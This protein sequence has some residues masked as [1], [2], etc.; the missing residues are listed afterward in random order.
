MFYIIR[1]TYFVLTAI[2][3]ALVLPLALTGSRKWRNRAGYGM[4]VDNAG[5]V[6][7][8]A[9]S[10]GETRALA[11]FTREWRRRYPDTRF[12]ISV[13]TDNGYRVACE[14]FAEDIAADSASVVF[15]PVDF[16]VACA[17]ALSVTR[18]S[19]CVITETE[20][21]PHW[22][23]AVT[24]RA[25]PIALVNA[26][27]SER[28]FSRYQRLRSLASDLLTRYA[29]IACQTEGDRN[30]YVALGAAP[31][32]AFVTGNLK[33]DDS[34][35]PLSARA[36]TTLR[37]NLGLGMADFALVAGS[38][39]EGEE[40]GVLGMVAELS[41]EFDNLR[42]IIAPRH[43]SLDGA[44]TEAARRRGL[45]LERTS[46]GP[47]AATVLLLDE[48]GRLTRVYG[49]G[50]LAFVGGTMTPIGGHNVLEPAR[51]G[52]PTVFGPHTANVAE[53]AAR[54][55]ATHAATQVRDWEELKGFVR[56]AVRGDIIFAR[57]R[58]GPQERGVAQ[59]TVDAALFSLER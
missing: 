37:R 43:S 15:L 28:S 42:L 20:I 19:L 18:P 34:G 26:R 32:R 6:W 25:I 55:V 2:A 47:S 35:E 29:V 59:K 33:G 57:W 24:G 52:I 30:R 36:R 13:M 21:W 40:D 14:V 11:V 7:A 17:R 12:V 1:F 22:I 39:R 16:P 5:C 8:H 44:I 41:R 38:V 49:A 56:E 4:P 46:A 23:Y 53:H 9:A 54:L 48:F 31:D 50:D 51:M 45:P 3:Y 10:V 27:L 58:P